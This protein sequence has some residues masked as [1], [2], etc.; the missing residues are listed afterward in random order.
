MSSRKP[1]PRLP[2]TKNEYHV[3]RTVMRMVFKDENTNESAIRQA[4]MKEAPGLMSIGH[5][6]VVLR[7]LVEKGYLR[8]VQLIPLKG[9]KRLM[10]HCTTNAGDDV[11]EQV[12]GFYEI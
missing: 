4:V 1:A 7:K 9:G 2:I 6:S 11:L 10:V 12:A 3:M 5:V 8:K